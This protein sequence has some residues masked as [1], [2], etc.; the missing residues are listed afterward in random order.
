MMNCIFQSSIVNN[1]DLRCIIFLVNF[2]YIFTNICSH[3]LI[4][5]SDSYN[6]HKNLIYYKSHKCL[7]LYTHKH[8]FGSMRD[9][10]NALSECI[11]N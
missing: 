6:G 3:F 4:S 1:Q 10:T 8:N 9:L 2:E 7:S 5:K 11:K